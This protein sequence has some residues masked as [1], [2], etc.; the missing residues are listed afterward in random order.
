MH[1]IRYRIIVMISER[2]PLTFFGLSGSIM[3]IL[4][5]IAG[6]RVL[7]ILA[8]SGVLPIGTTLISILFLTIG[9]F[10]IFTGIILH[11]IAKIES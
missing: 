4:G 6:V 5:V 7:Q 9:I 8:V 1:L 3:T 10:S 11:A 2:R